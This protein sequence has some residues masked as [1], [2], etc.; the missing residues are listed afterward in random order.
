M[1]AGAYGISRKRI[2]DLV[3]V[4]VLGN[5]RTERKGGFLFM[6]YSLGMM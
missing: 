4:V 1:L 6:V 5:C 3:T 2:R